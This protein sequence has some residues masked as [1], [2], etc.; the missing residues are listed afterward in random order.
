[1]RSYARTPKTLPNPV[2]E[3][4]T[5]SSEST[6]SK[7]AAHRWSSHP[8]PPRP[9]SSPLQAPRSA[10]ACTT[11]SWTMSCGARTNR[12]GWCSSTIR[13]AWSGI[14]TA[15]AA[16]SRCECRKNLISSTR[17]WAAAA[18]N[19]RKVPSSAPVSISSW[20]DTQ[21]G[22]TWRRTA[23][24]RAAS[25]AWKARRWATKSIAQQGARIWRR[26]SSAPPTKIAAHAWMVYQIW[27]PPIPEP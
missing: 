7:T 4:R 21:V 15:P 16:S 27:N 12:T 19:A 6:I 13:K 23:A 9:T 22:S 26:S 11:N 3:S 2:P 14:G 5:V 18:Y 8:I 25:A 10:S 24:L 20:N 1:M 17:C